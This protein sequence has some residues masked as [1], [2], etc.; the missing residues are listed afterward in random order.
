MTGEA[1]VL[2]G[3]AEAEA[4]TQALDLYLQ[5]FPAAART[6]GIHLEK[7]GSFNRDDVRQA[8]SAKVVVRVELNH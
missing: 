3:N 6:R 4:I 5:R 1:V 7:D 8:A 2:E